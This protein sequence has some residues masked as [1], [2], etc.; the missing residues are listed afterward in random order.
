MAVT[1]GLFL[2]LQDTFKH[3]QSQARA[4]WWV[5]L[6]LLARSEINRGELMQKLGSKPVKSIFDELLSFG[7]SSSKNSGQKELN[8]TGE[9]NSYMH[10]LL[11][12]CLHGRQLERLRK[13]TPSS[14]G[15]NLRR[16]HLRDVF[17]LWNEARK[18][19]VAEQS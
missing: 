15:E 14:F 4:F 6:G 17:S 2:L 3:Q 10:L 7:I 12:E 1:G 18:I 5:P 13:S 8:S 9:E 16:L 11:Q 19:R